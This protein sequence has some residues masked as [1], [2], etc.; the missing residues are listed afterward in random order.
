MS[1]TYEELIDIINQYI[2]TNKSNDVTGAKLNTILQEVSTY[3]RDNM[4]QL[5]NIV[6]NIEAGDYELPEASTNILG[7][8]KIDGQTI[9]KKPDGT[10]EAVVDTSNLATSTE[11]QNLSNQLINK[12]DNT[13]LKNLATKE[14]LPNLTENITPENE[15]VVKA[16]A[17]YNYTIKKVNTIADLR[18]T[19]GQEDGEVIELLGFDIKADK[20]SVKYIWN[21]ILL[22]DNN[23]TI[24]SNNSGSWLIE[25]KYYNYIKDFNNDIEKAVTLVNK[26]LIIDKEI[27]LQNKIILI[28]DITLNF[29][30]GKFKN[31]TLS[32]NFKIQNVNN[33]CIFENVKIKGLSTRN[34]YN[35]EWFV[36]Q[37]NSSLDLT[38]NK[39]DA[40]IEMQKAFD[41]GVEWLHFTN[42]YFLYTSIKIT[43]KCW[44][45]VTG[46]LVCHSSDRTPSNASPCWYTD[47]ADDIL[48]FI[49]DDQN[50]RLIV[51]KLYVKDIIIRRYNSFIQYELI[52]KASI[53]VVSNPDII[54]GRIWGIYINAQL[55]S[56][57]RRI[58]IPHPLNE[59]QTIDKWISNFKGIKI[60][61][62]ND[63]AYTYIKIYGYMYGFGECY[64]CKLDKTSASWITDTELHFDSFCRRGGTIENGY[65]LR[66]YGSHQPPKQTYANVY[67]NIG[68]FDVYENTLNESIVWDLA[69]GD[70]DGFYTVG[71]AFNALN[72]SVASLKD[73]VN[74]RN[75]TSSLNNY[76]GQEK[77]Y[78]LIKDEV[79][80]TKTDLNN[81]LESVHSGVI[82]NINPYKIY[83]HVTSSNFTYG[84]ISSIKLKS[85]TEEVIL[86]RNNVSNFNKLFK[87]SNYTNMGS[88]LVGSPFAQRHGDLAV[89]SDELSA[90]TDLNTYEVI[91]KMRT[92]SLKRY[93][94]YI[95][96]TALSDDGTNTIDLKI[97][98]EV[99]NA[100][101]F[102]EVINIPRNNMIYGESLIRSLKT[103]T[104]APNNSYCVIT[105]TNVM[106]P[107]ANIGRALPKFGLLTHSASNIVTSSGGE[108]PKNIVLGSVQ[109]HNYDNHNGDR[110]LY[111]EYV[112]RNIDI[113]NSYVRLFNFST[114]NQTT[115][116]YIHYIKSNG[117]SGVLGFRGGE[118]T[119]VNDDDL[120][121]RL[122]SK[123]INSSYINKRQ[124]SVK[125]E[126]NGVLSMVITD[127]ISS[128]T[129]AFNN[130]ETD[131]SSYTTIE[132]LRKRKSGTTAQRPILNANDLGFN[133][134]DTTLNKEVIWNGTLWIE[135]LTTKSTAVANVTTADATDLDTALVLINELKAK[136]NAKLA[137]DRASGQQTT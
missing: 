113:T 7:G 120:D 106:T 94:K 20:E 110:F 100:L 93:S 68:Y 72:S 28:N 98:S 11:V 44:V 87:F 5:L 127:I 79:F 84:E 40:S 96:A 22:D 105:Y 36:S 132:Y 29:K 35:I 24:I 134:F 3:T 76:E 53:S 2:T 45:K 30:G 75:L 111:N 54:N 85:S 117:K 126:T 114:Y 112:G 97:F 62:S 52:D 69:Q 73:L 77:S 102:S 14:E 6:E 81:I 55:Y 50:G 103:I 9:V 60:Y 32:G 19:V 116:I 130:I 92:Q 135:P 8:V 25:A 99:D 34:K 129:F 95:Y 119:Y 46:N 89:L 118:I 136:L 48:E 88:S 41:S 57:D 26:E 37:R 70:A 63:T 125:T 90:R 42:T 27:D 12:V 17:V 109:M 108:I 131:V 64:S 123:D 56:A 15:D 82:G 10:I 101:L 31:G 122:E 43:S 23:S 47:H 1:R 104:D 18:N 137:A 38:A 74:I 86:N 80:K 4:D 83:D 78:S 51:P 121:F 21:T 49:H 16:K 67:Q 115:R 91:F 124:L 33:D 107:L 13:E 39:K 61:A 71:N 65:P 128:R 66:V 59:G 133:F 58:T